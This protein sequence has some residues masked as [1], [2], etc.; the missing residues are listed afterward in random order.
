MVSSD[1][2]WWGLTTFF[3]LYQGDLFMFMSN[4]TIEIVG[5]V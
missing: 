2:V 3:A 1:F 4:V 5:E